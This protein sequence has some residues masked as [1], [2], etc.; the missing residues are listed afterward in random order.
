M[1]ADKQKMRQEFIE[2]CLEEKSEA[3]KM[4]SHFESGVLKTG[5]SGPEGYKDGSDQMM[6]HLRHVITN[7]DHLA[8][9]AQADMQSG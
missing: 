7:M 6:E 5:I 3:E 4:L 9:K 8:K 2:W 1:D